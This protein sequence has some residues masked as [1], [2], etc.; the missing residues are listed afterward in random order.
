MANGS[1]SV[2]SR[3]RRT[4]IV[5]FVTMSVLGFASIL[6]NLPPD[7]SLNRTWVQFGV[8]ARVTIWHRL[9][10]AR[11]SGQ[12]TPRLVNV[13]PLDGWTESLESDHDPSPRRICLRLR[14]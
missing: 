4:S 9:L 13:D 7:E 2:R 1:I 11:R 12:S 8:D 6:P 10:L 3:V 14:G 5:H